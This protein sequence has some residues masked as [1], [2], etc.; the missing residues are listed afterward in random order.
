MKPW[1]VAEISF[2]IENYSGV[3]LFFLTKALRL[4]NQQLPAN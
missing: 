3:I 1:Y 2:K 4:A